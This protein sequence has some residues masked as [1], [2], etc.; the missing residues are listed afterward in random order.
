[1]AK[2]KADTPEEIVAKR[3]EVEVLVGQ[4]KSVAD[5]IHPDGTG[6]QICWLV[7]ADTKRRSQACWALP[8][9]RRCQ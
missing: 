6:P 7:A 5:A 8:S 4:G 3:R 1:M 2:R 9:C